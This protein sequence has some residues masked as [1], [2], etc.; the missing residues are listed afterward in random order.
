MKNTTL[1]E[2]L[3]E[4]YATNGKQFTC[5]AAALTL[6]KK[7]GFYLSNGA[8]RN[9]H[10]QKAYLTKLKD[11]VYSN[12]GQKTIVPIGWLVTF[13]GNPISCQEL[14]LTPRSL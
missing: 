9:M 4:H 11:F 10:G 12:M 5:H 3:N 1:D 6:L 7:R 8:Y 13:G 14:V 2:K